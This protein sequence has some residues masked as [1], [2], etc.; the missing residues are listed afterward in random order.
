MWRRMRVAGKKLKVVKG[1]EPYGA[2]I[3]LY[4][5]LILPGANDFSIRLS[6]GNSKDVVRFRTDF[7]PRQFRGLLRAHRVRQRGAEE[8]F[9]TMM[10][11][12]GTDGS[13][14]QESTP[15]KQILYR[16]ASFA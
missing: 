5:Q 13:P 15:G 2:G 16:C 11:E 6:V 14:T 4:Q 12:S 10:E 3:C 7:Y 8:S 1:I 9:F